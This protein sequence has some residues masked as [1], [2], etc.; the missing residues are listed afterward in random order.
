LT[1][2]TRRVLAVC[3]DA[4]L[5][6]SAQLGGGGAHALHLLFPRLYLSV[7]VGAYGQMCLWHA[8]SVGFVLHFLQP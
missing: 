1:R 6:D 2:R 5:Q 8:K 7:E 3:V 4:A